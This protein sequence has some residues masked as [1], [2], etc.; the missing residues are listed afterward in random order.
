MGRTGRPAYSPLR[1]ESR[2]VPQ[3]LLKPEAR[4]R[5]RHPPSPPSR[6]R[7]ALSH[8]QLDTAH[9]E[10]RRSPAQ[11]GPNGNRQSSVCF[12]QRAR[13]HLSTLSVSQEL[14]QGHSHHSGCFATSTHQAWGFSAMCHPPTPVLHA[15]SLASHPINL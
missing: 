13:G 7:T 15:Q 9:G 10:R 3:I 1:G 4:R 6:K 5:Y 12:W 2:E 8:T 14:L 11:C